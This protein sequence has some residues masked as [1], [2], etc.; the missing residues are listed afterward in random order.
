MDGD[1]TISHDWH[2]QQIVAINR[3]TA[4]GERDAG[5]NAAL[6][7]SFEPSDEFAVFGALLAFHEAREAVSFGDRDIIFGHWFSLSSV[8]NIA[9]ITN[10]AHPPS[11][12]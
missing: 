4:A 6:A 3:V 8:H 2:V 9:R 5:G 11:Q 10:A 7:E 1:I 12:H